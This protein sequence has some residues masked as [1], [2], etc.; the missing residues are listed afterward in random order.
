MKLWITVLLCAAG[1][2]QAQTVWRCGPDGSSYADVPCRSGRALE[3]AAAR[4]AADL[5][6]A[7]DMARREKHLA[8]QL[9]RERQQQEAQRATAPAGI[10][11]SRLASAVEAVKPKAKARATGKRQLADADTW[12][13]VVP[14]SRR[15]KD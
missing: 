2:A 13:A 8:A 12:R 9:V 1:T 10:R 15:G 6:S 11:S 3:L 14:A 4:P 5:H 7:Q